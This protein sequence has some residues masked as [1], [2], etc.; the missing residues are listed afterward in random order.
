MHGPAMAIYECIAWPG[1]INRTAAM[2]S[3]VLKA[4]VGAGEGFGNESRF[5]VFLGHWKPAQPI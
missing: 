2:D 4:T 1:L 3:A 5:V